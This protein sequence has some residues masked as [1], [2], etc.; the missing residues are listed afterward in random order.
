MRNKRCLLGS[1]NPHKMCFKEKFAGVMAAV[2]LI[3]EAAVVVFE[4]TG[5]DYVGNEND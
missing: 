2:S 5:V 4:E 3:R 1:K